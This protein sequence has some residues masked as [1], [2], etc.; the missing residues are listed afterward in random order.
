[1]RMDAD[2]KRRLEKKAA[3]LDRSVAWVAQHAIKDYLAREDALIESVNEILENDDGRR[4][5]GEAVMAW[6]ERWADGYD[7]PFPEADIFLTPEQ[8]KKS[9]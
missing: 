3:H 1:M 7:D 8:I 6:M 2:T 9:A 5:S 4:I